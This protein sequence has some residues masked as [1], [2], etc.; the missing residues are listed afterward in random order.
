MNRHMFLR[1]F[2][3]ILLLVSLVSSIC[4][5]TDISGN[6]TGVLQTVASPYHVKANLL[7]PS[8]ADLRIQPGV[9]LIF[10]GHYY[11]D[12]DG[13]IAVEGT[14]AQ[15]VTFT[16]TDHNAG[17]AGIRIIG[18]WNDNIFS[19]AVFEYGRALASYS[20]PY[21][22]ADMEGAG[23]Y[24]D[25][26]KVRIDGCVFQYNRATVH[27]SAFSAQ[28]CV[29]VSVRNSSFFWND[30]TGDCA[31]YGPLIFHFANSTDGHSIKLLV[32]GCE[33]AHNTA[34]DEAAGL[35]II[36]SPTVD[37]SAVVIAR[38]IQIVRIVPGGRKQM[39]I[40]DDKRTE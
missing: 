26:G 1:C 12:V 37:P 2:S 17:W 39:A 21:H 38:R 11:L 28:N 7:V 16:A 30:T 31:G 14:D 13:V 20:P 6:V 32:D 18:N 10:D 22:S 19:N 8:G 9:T 40:D 4:P 33:I 27:G 29:D 34:R 36:S 5:A 23:I 15:P 24:L 3:I 25:D 35:G